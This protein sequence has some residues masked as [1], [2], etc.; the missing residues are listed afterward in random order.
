[1]NTLTRYLR[2]DDERAITIALVL[3]VT[4]GIDND[5]QNA[6]AASGAMHVLAVSG[7]HVGIIY[8]IILFLFKPLT[9]YRWSKWVVAVTSLSL[10]WGFAFVTGLL[11]PCCVP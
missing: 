3:G 7:M 9:K 10:L 11:L 1:M 5:L 8:A 2:G 4:D 6:Y